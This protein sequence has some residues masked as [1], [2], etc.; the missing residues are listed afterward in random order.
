MLER[1]IER[2][3]D[4]LHVVGRKQWKDPLSYLDRITS[5]YLYQFDFV[6]DSF[7]GNNGVSSNRK[8]CGKGIC[9]I[10]LSDWE[11][12]IVLCNGFALVGIDTLDFHNSQRKDW[13]V[14][15]GFPLCC[16]VPSI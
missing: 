7:W 6:A 9:K 2:P 4:T 10:W 3:C 1:G 5:F 8:G 16:F 11:G 13:V 15:K 12:R 14:S